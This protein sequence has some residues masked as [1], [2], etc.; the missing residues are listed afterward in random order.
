MD[1]K[2]IMVIAACHLLWGIPGVMGERLHLQ[3]RRREFPGQEISFPFSIYVAAFCGG[4][5]ILASEVFDRVFAPN[6]SDC[7]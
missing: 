6:N 5:V 7:T 2:I 3:R 1:I 4:W